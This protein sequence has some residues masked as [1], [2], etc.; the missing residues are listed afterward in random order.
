VIVAL[1]ALVSQLPELPS[2][3]VL[4][5][6]MVSSCVVISASAGVGMF[7]LFPSFFP[8]AINRVLMYARVEGRVSVVRASIAWPGLLSVD[9]ETVTLTNPAGFA[10]EALLLV[11]KLGVT[12]SIWSVFSW[13]V[14]VVRLE[15]EDITV[16]LERKEGLG[17]NAVRYYNFVRRGDAEEPARSEEE[18]RK[19]TDTILSLMGVMPNEF[20]HSLSDKVG[21]VGGVRNFMKDSVIATTNG[22]SGFIEMT[23]QSLQDRASGLSASVQEAGGFSKWAEATVSNTF[24]SIKGKA[25]DA[26]RRVDDHGIVAGVG[27][28]AASEFRGFAGEITNA[29]SDAM[30]Y[31]QLHQKIAGCYAEPAKGISSLRVSVEKVSI[32]RLHVQAT[33]LI[34]GDGH[35]AFTLTARDIELDPEDLVPHAKAKYQDGLPLFEAIRRLKVMTNATIRTQNKETLVK[36]A[37]AG[38]SEVRP[39]DWIIKKDW[40]SKK[41]KPPSPTESSSPVGRLTLR[42][43]VSPE[44]GISADSAP[45]SKSSALAR[46]SSAASDLSQASRKLPSSPAG[47]L[48]P[49]S[50]GGSSRAE[51]IDVPEM[52]DTHQKG[53]RLLKGAG[54]AVSGFVEGTSEVAPDV[55]KGTTDLVGNVVGGAGE[56][57][58]K[59]TGHAGFEGASKGFS[60][61]LDNVGDSFAG[62]FGKPSASGGSDAKDTKKKP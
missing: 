16:W 12:L 47:A 22:A 25:E 24:D 19:Q 6:A 43:A 8:A 13:C 39:L 62:L 57:L 54:E 55:I 38:I 30:L 37:Q 15:A 26:R 20:I 40:T 11:A 9:V 61:A 2:S 52:D 32:K 58:S 3:V 28:S 4:Y 50:G 18:A 10:N 7:F 27:E 45:S 14:K 53:R 41:N 48:A 29:A 31:E 17:V 44:R 35:D 33:G 46:P 60:G 42:T 23:G 36:M 49:S 1:G 56:A 5:L 59:I 21:G 51:K 34:R